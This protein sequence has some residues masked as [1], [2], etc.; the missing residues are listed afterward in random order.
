MIVRHVTPPMASASTSKSPLPVPEADEERC[1]ICLQDIIDRTLLPECGHKYTCFQCICTWITSGSQ[2]H[3]SRRC[4]LCNTPI[5]SFIIHNLRGEHDFQKHWLPPPVTEHPASER[6][7]PLSRPL[8][9][10]TL[11]NHRPE[12]RHRRHIRW[13]KRPARGYQELDELER[14]IEQRRHIYRCNLFAKVW[15]ALGLLAI[16]ADTEFIQHVAS[17]RHTR[18]KPYPTPAQIAASQDMCS[19]I[20]KFVRRELRVWEGLD[21]EVDSSL[22]AVIND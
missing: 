4:P 8:T 11:S 12:N 9:G 20:L 1:I 22:C 7:A 10:R 5:G 17:N 19:R 15:S 6:L 3:S 14:A 18:Y 16:P 21:I 2:T 13:G